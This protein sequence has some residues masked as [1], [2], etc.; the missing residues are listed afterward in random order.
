MSDTVIATKGLKKFYGRHAAVN[1][2]D[3]SI[4]QGEIFGLLGPNGAGKTTTILMLLGLTEANE[5]AITVV[6]F[7]PMREPLEVKRRVGYLPDSVGFYDNLT[8][9]QNLRYTARLAGL[10]R[11]EAERR[12]DDA[13]T[14]VR[15]TEVARN[16]VGTF[17]H[18]MRQ[19]LGLAEVMMK[20][21]EV[22]ILDEP[23]SG[24]DPQATFELLDMIRGLKAD[25]VAVLISSHLLDRVQ[26]VCDRVALFNRGKIALEGTVTELS[27][28][29]LGGGYGVEVEATGNDLPLVFS[30]V[31]GVQR[32]AEAGQGKFH[33]VAARDVRAELGQ[34]I[35]AAG[36]SLLRLDHIEPTPH[37]IYRPHFEGENGTAERP[38]L[39]GVRHRPPG[40]NWRSSSPRA[41]DPPRMGGAADRNRCG[42][43][44]DPGPEDD[45]GA[46]PVPVPPPLHQ[47]ARATALLHGRARISH[48]PYGDRPGV[49]CGERRI[50]SSHD[51]PHP[52]AAGLSRRTAAR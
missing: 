36:G 32:V 52:R 51:E 2:I 19:R 4:R 23:T 44:G 31:P 18:G 8:A 10:N 35:L 39:G 49:R 20:R 47:R 22:A 37:T 1:G 38:D 3:L 34:A 29:V 24:L 16:K 15:L 33:I 25:R 6:G 45:D 21:A 48:P 28:K 30:R 27:Q 50:Q 40:G 9:Q 13:L 7:D 43:H 11:A 46:G 26:A 42:L 41:P 14:R 17:S 5:G 12:I